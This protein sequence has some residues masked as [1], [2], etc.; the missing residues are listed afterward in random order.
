VGVNSEKYCERDEEEM[1]KRS[2]QQGG[3]NERERVASSLYKDCMI[4]RL[5]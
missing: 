4:D 3:E 2:L 5:L 1:R